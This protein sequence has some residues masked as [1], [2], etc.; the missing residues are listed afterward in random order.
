MQRTSTI[1]GQTFLGEMINFNGKV[2]RVEQI[3]NKPRGERNVGLSHN[4]NLYTVKR[5][6]EYLTVVRA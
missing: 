4:G 6:G 3:E 1:I 2:Y 5:E